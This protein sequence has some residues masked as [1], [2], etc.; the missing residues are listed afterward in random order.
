[1]DIEMIE[2]DFRDKVQITGKLD[3]GIFGKMS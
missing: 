3:S 2:S 1:M